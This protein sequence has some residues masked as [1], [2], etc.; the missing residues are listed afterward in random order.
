MVD[1]LIEAYGLHLVCNVYDVEVAESEDLRVFHGQEYIDRLLQIRSDGEDRE[2]EK[3][4]EIRE[5][6]GNRKV[7]K[8]SNASDLPNY[9]LIYDCAPFPAL[10]DYVLHVAG[11]S[12]SAADILVKAKRRGTE[13]RQ[14]AINWYG[15]RHHCL[16][17]RAA[18]FCYV[19][20]IV[21][22][23]LRL[24][25]LF[26]RIFYL[27][28]DLHHGDGVENAFRHSKNVVTCSIHR[29]GVGFYPGTGASSLPGSYNVPTE[30]GF[31]DSNL[32][33]VIKDLVLPLLERENPEVLVIQCG[34]DGLA[35]DPHKEWNL[36][37]PGLTEA[38]MKVINF[39]ENTHVLLLG[40]GGYNHRDTARLWCHI[41]KTVAGVSEEYL[42]IPNHPELD[43]FFDE[44]FQ[45]WTENVSRPKPGRKDEN[46]G[47]PLDLFQC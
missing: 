38:V 2:I 30:R 8:E 45:F 15:G 3:I 14:I 28:L 22:A 21:L 31:S 34:A 35:S 46:H 26:R 47:F 12:L 19:N 4:G 41:T 16:R 9:G 37:I 36:T 13:D 40:G 24:R 1:T 43:C 44:G 27:D 42:E 39:N 11:A 25:R 6:E 5:L 18:G 32:H 7:G 23:I 10:A 20:D 33:H 29:H 17:D